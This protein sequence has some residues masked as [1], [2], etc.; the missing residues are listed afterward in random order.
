ML[1]VLFLRGINVGGKNKVSMA[2]LKQQLVAGGFT[3][4]VTCLN[5]GNI[6]LH[7]DSAPAEIRRR[8]Q[9]LLEENYAFPITFALLSGEQY[10]KEFH[11]L[12]D[13][14]REPMSRRDVLFF[15]E[16]VDREEIVRS[17]AGMKL[18]SERVYIGEYAVFWGKY[19]EREYLKTAYHKLLLQQPY[20]KE[21]TIRNENTCLRMLELLKEML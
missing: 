8:L 10:R 11:S 5:S 7:S 2:L 4:I 9:G 21:I 13:W 19:E 17:I 18:G 3:G 20:Y 12:P 16:N 14:W 15:T 1:Y 6:L